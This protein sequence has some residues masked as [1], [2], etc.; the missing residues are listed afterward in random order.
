MYKLIVLVLTVILFSCG[1]EKVTDYAQ[2]SKDL[3]KCV[4]ETMRINEQLATKNQDIDPQEMLVLMKQA[5]KAHTQAMQ[6]CDQHL[7]FMDEVNTDN[8]VDEFAQHCSG[9]PIELVTEILEKA[10]E[11]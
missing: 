11:E 10:S 4:E 7:G 8:L 3:C 9:I 1:S 6:C 2:L 5:Q